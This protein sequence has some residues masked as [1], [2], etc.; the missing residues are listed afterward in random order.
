MAAEAAEMTTTTRGLGGCLFR[1]DHRVVDV[2]LRMY[3]TDSL[4][5]HTC[6]D[7]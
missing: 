6:V 2:H 4:R 5:T 7:M 1:L 3:S